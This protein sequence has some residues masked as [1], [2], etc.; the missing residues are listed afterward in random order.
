MKW[1]PVGL[2]YLPTFPP[3]CGCLKYLK[4]LFPGIINLEWL[5]SQIRISLNLAQA[6]LEQGKTFDCRRYAGEA[7]KYL[8]NENLK[9]PTKLAKVTNRL[10]WES[11]KGQVSTW[12]K[13]VAWILFWFYICGFGEI[14]GNLLLYWGTFRAVINY[15]PTVCSFMLK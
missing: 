15:L 6:C 4:R 9:N 10:S 2:Y 14:R 12:P 3:S 13:K 5:N 7:A 11:T 8:L 1:W